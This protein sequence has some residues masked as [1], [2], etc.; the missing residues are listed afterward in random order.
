MGRITSPQP[1]GDRGPGDEEEPPADKL[2]FPALL[3]LQGCGREQ[4]SCTFGC[5]VVPALAGTAWSALGSL[6]R[7]SL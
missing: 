3:E 6:F 2:L 4:R 7:S 1:S 5:S